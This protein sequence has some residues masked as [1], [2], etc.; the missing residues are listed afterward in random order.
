M[1]ERVERM[2]RSL[3]PSHPRWGGLILRELLFQARSL[4]A[5]STSMVQPLL[6]AS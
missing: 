2:P 3:P 4:E 1:L 5:L 6:Q